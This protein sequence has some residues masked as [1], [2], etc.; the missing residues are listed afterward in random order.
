MPLA[1]KDGQEAFPVADDRDERF[2]HQ[3]PAEDEGVGFVERGGREE[4]LVGELG[5]VQVGGEE[6]AGRAAHR[7][8]CSLRRVRGGPSRG[9]PSPSSLRYSTGISSWIAFRLIPWLRRTK[10]AIA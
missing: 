8:C 10:Y 1:A 3:V 9:R 4:L 5:A 6:D 7:R 2:A